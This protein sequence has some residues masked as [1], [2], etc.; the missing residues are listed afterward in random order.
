MTWFERRTLNRGTIIAGLWVFAGYYLGAKIGFALTFE[1]RPVSVLWPPNAILTATLLLTPPRSWWV[2]LLAA[3]PAHWAAQLE[4][5]VPP[6]MILSWFISNCC[7]AL[8]GAGLARYLIDG[9]VR[10]TNL[11]NVAIFGLC[12]VFTGPF[13]SSFLDA[14]LVRWNDW[15]TGSYWELWRVRLTSNFLASLTITSLIVT[16]ATTGFAALKAAPRQRL[17]EA[18]LLLLGL[19]FASFAVFLEKGSGI[20]SALLYLPLPFLLWAAV[21]FGAYGASTA[22]SIIA[23]SAIGSAAYGHGPFSNGSPEENA[24]AIQLFLVVMALP[25]MFLAALI[26][27]HTKTEQDLRDSEERYRE[28]VE[29]QTELVCRYLPD[30]TLTF[31][32][33]AYCRFFKRRR[34]DLIGQRFLDLVPPEA[35]DK[36][37]ARI[38]GLTRDH[39]MMTH[40]HEVTMPDGSSGWQQWIDYAILDADGHVR[41]YQGI[42]RDITERV[43]AEAALSEREA[44]ISLAAESAN[45]ALWVYEPAQDTAWMSEKGRKIYG[46]EPDDALSRAHLA[47]SVH[48]DDREAIEAAFD[49]TDDCAKPF[50]IEHRIVKPDGETNWAITRGRHL[51]D[52]HGN[53][54]EL[55]GVTIDITAQKKAALQLQA[56]REE[57]AHFG[58]LAAMGEI[59]VSL[60][61]ELTQP[62]TGIVCN[63]DAGR[64]IIDHRKVDI[65]ELRDLLADISADGRR[66]GNVIHGIRRMVKRGPVVRRPI[67]LN[68]LV[69]ELVQ[70]VGTEALLRSCEIK[71]VLEPGLPMVMGDP[72]ELQQVLLNLVVNAFDAMRGL[73]P[74]ERKVVITTRWNESGS[75][76]VDVLDHGP[77]LSQDVRE[78]LFE[79]FFTTKAEGLGM[80]LAIARTIAES[81]GGTIKAENTASGGAQFSLTL[82]AAAPAAWTDM[83]SPTVSPRP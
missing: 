38:A 9:P 35:R 5:Q 18:F 73:P 25:L 83:T 13:L 31:I 47:N 82:P 17:A 7:E 44:R 53:I 30:T 79:Q 77:G 75:V 46:F 65:R 32:N 71:T 36:V 78:R 8:I 4:S 64:L 62:L 67:N 19:G 33:E 42:G 59:A 43:R 63:A 23:F 50:E 66:A 74:R 69:R 70:L 1:P 28:V 39:R 72:V 29:S 80:G 12:V 61:H 41:E 3:L 15:G 10:L 20:S 34:E 58:R 11:R 45:V 60:A 37:A 51:C 21:R 76:E 57:I 81:H 55:I 40:E 26:E 54:V 22:S 16:W 52:E 24:L 49:R 2:I 48:P 14:A 68:D 6:L 27:E 56:S